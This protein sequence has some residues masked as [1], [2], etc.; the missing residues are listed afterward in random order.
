M[1]RRLAA[2]LAA[3]LLLLTAVPA[4]RT[5]ETVLYSAMPADPTGTR[6]GGPTDCFEYVP[7]RDETVHAVMTL[8]WNGGQG[9]RPGAISV[10]EDDQVLLGV[11]K[12]AGTGGEGQA[13]T[14]WT[15][16]PNVVFR[17][18]HRYYICDSDP[19][20]WSYDPGR[21]TLGIELRGSTEAPA[22]GSRPVYLW[23]VYAL[24]DARTDGTPARIDVGE[25]DILLEALTVF[26]GG[27]PGPIGLVDAYTGERL[28]PWQAAGQ[29][30]SAS[31]TVVCP[32]VEL[33]AMHRYY[34]TVSDGGLSGQP[35]TGPYELVGEALP[36]GFMAT[37]VS[38]WAE[39]E[40]RRAAQNGLFPPYLADRDLT[41]PV[42][43]AE[44]AAAAV[45]LYEALSGRQAAAARTPFADTAGHPLAEEIAKAY[46]LN[47]AVG[48][49]ETVFDPD[50]QLTREQM[51][52]MLLRALKK[53]EHEDW[54]LDRDAEY[55]Y[56][57][58]MPRRFSDDA[59]I[60]DWARDSVYCMAAGGYIEGTGS[61]RFDPQGTASREQALAVAVRMLTGSR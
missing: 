61:R 32:R 47:L 11:W 28:G 23:E 40:I 57:Y 46:T 49:S 31:G 12:A 25:R 2:L 16:T 59:R 35:F 10:W 51:A 56:E 53:A 55:P 9:V 58:E 37:H 48:M 22:A 20:S 1:I 39:F 45:M 27:S 33:K 54:T 21:G 4:A 60:S 36:S 38:A 26:P 52:A 44:F 24:C 5:A 18:G 50:A 7:S 34:I 41:A 29:S 30:E 17:A 8:H 13:D 3:A 42:T 19:G 14:R 15:V 6:N 43:R